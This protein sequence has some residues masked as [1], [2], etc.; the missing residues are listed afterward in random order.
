MKLMNQRHRYNLQ[1]FAGKK[2]DEGGEGDD[3]HDDDED[4]GDDEDEPSQKKSKKSAKTFTQEELD[5]AIERRLKRE[6]MKAEKEKAQ[7]EED[8]KK[9]PEEKKDEKYSK[10]EAQLQSMQ[11]KMICLEHGVEKSNIKDVVALANTYVDEDTDFEEAL[12]TVLKKYPHFA[13]Q[14][15]DEEDETKKKQSYKPKKGG[16]EK[17]LNPWTDAINN[18]TMQAE[19]VTENPELARELAAAAGK[20]LIF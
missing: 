2:T 9:S 19:I 20:T 8:K 3:N 7:Q 10:M 17:L 1:L 5:A 14:Q 18:L 4:E 15:E 16:K 11:A 6:R 12:E 13:K